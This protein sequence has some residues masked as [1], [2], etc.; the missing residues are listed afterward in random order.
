MASGV[1]FYIKNDIDNNLYEKI[2]VAINNHYQFC[3]VIEEIIGFMPDWMWKDRVNVARNKRVSK[4]ISNARQK[5]N[6]KLKGILD[7]ITK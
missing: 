5:F 3:D 7:N 4:F 6:Q 1:R 2:D